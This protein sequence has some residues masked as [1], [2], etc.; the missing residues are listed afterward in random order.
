MTFKEGTLTISKSAHDSKTLSTIEIEASTSTV[1]KKVDLSSYV[2]DNATL[3]SSKTSG[4]LSIAVGTMSSKQASFTIK[5]PEGGKE[6]KAVLTIASDAYDD[7]TVTVPFKVKD[8]SA[9]QS[10]S[11]S[12]GSGFTSV[13]AVA[14]K[15]LDTYAKQNLSGD[16]REAKLSVVPKQSTDIDTAAKDAILNSVKASYL[17]RSSSLLNLTESDVKVEFL[18]ITV[19]AS[20]SSRSS[21]AVMDT[22]SPIEIA[23]SMPLANKADLSVYRY[24]G[25]SVVKLTELTAR[26]SS[27]SDGTF[28]ADTSAGVLYIYSRYFSIYTIAYTSGEANGAATAASASSGSAKSAGSPKTGDSS[29]PIAVFAIALA[30]G[31]AL[32]IPTVVKKRSE[33]DGDVPEAQGGGAPDA[34]NEGP[35]AEGN[36]DSDE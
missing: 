36:E 2:P 34:P 10:A 13:T 32:A 5:A 31:A 11:L 6:G 16:N 3:K 35:D 12:R 21:E 8:Q 28:F 23:L 9:T 19:T 7:F 33:S 17:D 30:I 27:Y 29:V 26:P 20:S 15:G 25:G 14:V 4:D 18:D 22:K 24:H 1:T